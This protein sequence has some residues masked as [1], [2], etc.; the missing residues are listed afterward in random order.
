MLFSRRK[1]NANLS[2]ITQIEVEVL[3]HQGKINGGK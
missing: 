3:L 1:D 2:E